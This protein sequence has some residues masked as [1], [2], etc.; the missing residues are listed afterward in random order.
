[1]GTPIFC[2][3]SIPKRPYLKFRPRR[4]SVYISRAPRK[5]SGVI[6]KVGTRLV[7]SQEYEA[8]LH[9]ER[10]VG[11]GATSYS[12]RMKYTEAAL[13][14]HY[15]ATDPVGNIKMGRIWSAPRKWGP[16]YSSEE[17]YRRGLSLILERAGVQDIYYPTAPLYWRRLFRNWACV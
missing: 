8:W 13:S 14:L 10:A 1:M 12:P 2:G 9:L 15:R 5:L 16:P 11:N 7:N 6:S 4:S 17:V 3:G